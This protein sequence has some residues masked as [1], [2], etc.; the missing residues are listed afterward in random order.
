MDSDY[1]LSVLHEQVAFWE[2]LFNPIAVFI[3][4][5]LLLVFSV[6][7]SISEVAYFS[8]SP[9]ET[10]EIL[11]EKKASDPLVKRLISRPEYLLASVFITRH[12]VNVTIVLF[13]AFAFY[14]YVNFSAAPFAGFL[15]VVL[16]LSVLLVLIEVLP[17]RY[18]RM[19][20]LKMV[21]LLAPWVSFINF[22]CYPFSKLLV[23]STSFVQKK[24]AKMNPDKAAGER[25]NVFDRTS[26]F[27]DDKE[28]IA[29]V[30]RFYNKTA[31]EIMTSRLDIEDLDIRSG[32]RAVVSFVLDSGY[33]RIPVYEDSEDNMKGILYLRDLLPYLDKTDDFEWQQLIRP[34]YFVPE[35]KKIDDLLEEFRTNK[36][37]MAVVVDEFG[38]TS[39]IVTMEDILEEIVGEI[40][41]EYDEDDKLCIRLADG[42]FIVKAKIL[43]TNFFRM[44]DIDPAEFGELTEEVETLGGLLLEIKG[45]FPRLK[46]V[47]EYKK[48]RFQILEIDNRRILKVK[49]SQIKEEESSN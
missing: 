20:S 3:L 46:E 5:F 14:S 39:G 37:H 18:G 38:G 33:S 24:L 48:Y 21:R 28:M 29:E 44:T 34:A 11:G 4:L 47:I 22:L 12:I 16:V 6:F 2:A 49:F 25:T 30:I 27:V 31:D 10:D 1:Y 9:D 17:K 26:N 7:M 36:I 42:S 43:L 40:F 13:S 35:T 41:D 8:L 23:T 19:Y 45:G 32:F 15:L